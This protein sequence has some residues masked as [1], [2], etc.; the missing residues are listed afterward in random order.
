M[1][2]NTPNAE[3]LSYKHNVYK[4]FYN[5]SCQISE[6][7]LFSYVAPVIMGENVCFLFH[8]HIDVSQFEAYKAINSILNNNICN[9]INKYGVDF[10]EHFDREFTLL[11]VR[12]IDKNSFCFGVNKPIVSQDEGTIRTEGGKTVTYEYV[13]QLNTVLVYKHIQTAY[14]RDQTDLDEWSSLPLNPDQG[15][16]R[17]RK[18]IRHILRNMFCC[19]SLN[20]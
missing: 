9:F 2:G 13:M 15:D 12:P 11:W 7:W 18:R 14:N 16:D 19:I 17:P 10:N 20:L 1:K 3:L 5:I 8:K 4:F 6:T